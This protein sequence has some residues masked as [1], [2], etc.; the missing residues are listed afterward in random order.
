MKFN[1]SYNFYKVVLPKLDKQEILIAN[2][3]LQTLVIIMG[4]I[5]LM[6]NIGPNLSLAS[7]TMFTKSSDGALF[8]SFFKSPNFKFVD[9]TLPENF[10][11][12]IFPCTEQDY[13][14]HITQESLELE[15]G[16]CYNSEELIDKFNKRKKCFLSTYFKDNILPINFK[17]K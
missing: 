11:Y 12:L 1:Y 9:R 10:D 16:T 5:R 2:S 3:E 13:R 17:N 8:Y 4:G 7:E 15:E 14:L 6:S